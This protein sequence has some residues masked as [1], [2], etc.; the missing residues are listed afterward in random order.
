MLILMGFLCSCSGSI[1]STIGTMRIASLLRALLLVVFALSPTLCRVA[2]AMEQSPQSHSCC[3]HEKQQP[4]K[5]PNDCCSYATGPVE[6]KDSKISNV[7]KI[8]VDLGPLGGGV[9]RVSVDFSP[10][11][12]DLPASRA[13]TWIDRFHFL[14]LGSNAPP[15]A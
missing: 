4:E 9:L 11:T 10:R 5:A 6:A 15:K 12:I 2:C 8:L 3:P 7:A 1:C 14:P 13:F